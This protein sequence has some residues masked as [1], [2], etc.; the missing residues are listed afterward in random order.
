MSLIIRPTSHTS[1]TGSPTNPTYA[2]DAD[3][4]TYAYVASDHAGPTVEEY[5]L[6][7]WGSDTHEGKAKTLRYK[8][9]IITLLQRRNNLRSAEVLTFYRPLGLLLN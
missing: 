4:D 1:G 9:D 6:T 2:Y 3:L 8:P 5:E 7:G